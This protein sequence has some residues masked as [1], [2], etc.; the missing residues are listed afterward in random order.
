M[1]ELPNGDRR[2]FLFGLA[3]STLTAACTKSSPGEDGL[4]SLGDAPKFETQ[5]LSGDQV[6]LAGLRGTVVL[7]NTWATWCKPC[8]RELPVLAQLHDDLGARGFT[9]IGLNMDVR[10]KLPEVRRMIAHHQ[11]PFPIWLDF[12]SKAQVAFKLRGYPTSLLID[13]EGTI[14]WRREGEILVNDPELMATL[15]QVLAH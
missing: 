9:V 3:A 4:A 11:L 10:K 14:R 7:L 1:N 8:V 15:E 2:R 5:A 6:S 13:R 12:E